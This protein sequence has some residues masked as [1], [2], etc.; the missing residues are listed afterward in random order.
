MQAQILC[1]YGLSC[2]S[3]IRYCNFPLLQLI[4]DFKDKSKCLGFISRNS[5]ELQE[6][7]RTRLE[8]IGVEIPKI[9]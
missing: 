6:E 2:V 9:T 8:E 3:A 5:N 4:Y 1:Y 7:A